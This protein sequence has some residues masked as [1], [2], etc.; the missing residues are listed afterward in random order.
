MPEKISNLCTWKKLNSS[1]LKVQSDILNPSACGIKLLMEGRWLEIN[2][3]LIWPQ[4]GK[5]QFLYDNGK[6]KFG[7]PCMKFEKQKGLW[8]W[9]GGGG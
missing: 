1:V 9:I 6:G 5:C 2:V 3:Y 7:L 8:I 4:E